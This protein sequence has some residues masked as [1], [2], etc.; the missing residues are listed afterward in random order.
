MC[1]PN[2][3][4]LAK[5]K[6][7]LNAI[8]SFDEE[9]DEGCKDRCAG[10][11]TDGYIEENDKCWAYTWEPITADKR[12]KNCHL[13]AAKGEIKASTAEEDT[14]LFC[15]FKGALIENESTDSLMT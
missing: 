7:A 14:E 5:P 4:L 13:W 1:V 10:K 9:T 8:D 3:Q 12:T 2:S 6:D 11:Q 15:N